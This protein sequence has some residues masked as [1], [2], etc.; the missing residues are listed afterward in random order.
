MATT[1]SPRHSGIGVAAVVHQPRAEIW[2]LF[3]DVLVL[4]PGGAMAYCGPRA[5]VIPY[6]AGLGYSLPAFGVRAA[7]GK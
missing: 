5:E 2:A 7:R 6:F 4:C 3:D 1:P